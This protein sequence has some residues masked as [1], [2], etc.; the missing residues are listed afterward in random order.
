MFIRSARKEARAATRAERSARAHAE[1][2]IRECQ[3]ELRARAP[4]YDSAD[5]FDLKIL[6]VLE[7][8]FLL[9]SSRITFK[10]G[11]TMIYLEYLGSCKLI[12]GGKGPVAGAGS[13]AQNISAAVSFPLHIHDVSFRSQMQK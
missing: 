12:R 3:R 10:N 2:Q 11:S 13:E 7:S 6:K 1:S 5:S 4:M 8:C 9:N